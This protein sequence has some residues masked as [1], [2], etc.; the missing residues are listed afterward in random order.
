MNVA[1]KTTACSSGEFIRGDPVPSVGPCVSWRLPERSFG[2]VHGNGVESPRRQAG[3]LPAVQE[4]H[5]R[6]LST[7][8][9]SQ[10]QSEAQIDGHG[11]GHDRDADRRATALRAI[12]PAATAHAADPLKSLDPAHHR[13]TCP[14][15][16]QT[17]RPLHPGT[18]PKHCRACRTSPRHSP[19][20]GARDEHASPYPT[21]S[22]CP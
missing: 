12:E 16:R 17:R 20:S 1:G 22:R 10:H 13:D 8:F 4:G 18:I 9:P 19:S 11:A 21:C 15:A 7:D 2:A 14:T 5:V 3:R 6:E